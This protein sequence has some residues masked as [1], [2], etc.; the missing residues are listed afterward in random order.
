MRTVRRRCGCLGVAVVAHTHADVLEV[1]H[2][3][4][5]KPTVFENVAYTP[6]KGRGTVGVTVFDEHGEQVGRFDDIRN[7]VARR[8]HNN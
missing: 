1:H 4:T 3:D 8:R 7:T 6:W 5:D 2:H